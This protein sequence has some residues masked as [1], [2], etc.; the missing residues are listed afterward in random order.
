M[1]GD[2]PTT[3]QRAPL[4]GEAAGA[5]FDLGFEGFAGTA[6]SDDQPGDLIARYRLIALLGEGGFGLVWSAEQ[7]EPIQRELALKLI[8]RGMDSREI[9][10]RFEAES[11]AL[12]MMDHP[13]IAAVL[14][15]GTSADGRPWFAM[16]LVKGTPLVSYCD[17]RKL[18]VRERIELF[19]PV[20]QA[21]Q[22]AHQKAILHR[23]LKPTNILVAEID[24]KPV[25]KVIDFGIAKALGTPQE[26]AASLLQTRIG[27][28]VGT[29]QYMSPE[30]AGSVPDVDTRSDIYSL[31][32]ILYELLTGTTSLSPG[33]E[34]REPSDE[35]LRRIRAEEAIR[36]SLRLQADSVAS[37]EVAACRGTEPAR[38]RKSLRGDLD[39]IVLKALEKDRRRRYGT[40]TAF[41]TDLRRYLDQ[42]PVSAAA[43]TWSY[44]FPKFARR[45]RVAFVTVGLVAAALIAGTVVSLNQAAR[46]KQAGALAEQNR[47]LAEKNRAEAEESSAR[48]MKAMEYFLNG[49]TDDPRLKQADFQDLRRSLLEAAL[50]MYRDLAKS[51]GD[52]P[53]VQDKRSWALGRLGALYLELGQPGKAITAMREAMELSEALAAGDP[54]N[55]LH[56]RALSMRLNN[57]SLPLRQLDE[58][59]EAL[60]LQRRGVGISD[61][62]AADF[63]G[64]AKYR[65]DLSTV[66]VNFGA[67][68]REE[69]LLD[70]SIA[71]H[72]RA[73]E[74]AEK[75]VADFPGDP[76]YLGQ[77]AFCHGTLA[78]SLQGR[79]DNGGAEQSYRRAREIWEKLATEQVENTGVRGNLAMNSHNLG[80]LLTMIGRPAEGLE[81]LRHGQD[82]YQRL[83]AEF[84]S[85]PGYRDSLATCRYS[86]GKALEKLGRTWEAESEFQQAL[87][88]YHAL[89][90]DF[91]GEAEHPVREGLA[92]E[93]L[94]LLQ[95]HERKWDAARELY[96]RSISRHR[97]ALELRPGTPA[98]RNLI[99]DR[100]KA[101]AEMGLEAGDPHAVVKAALQI[102]IAIPD[103]WE[104]QEAAA[105]LVARALP[106]I[107]AHASMSEEARVEFIARCNASIV[108][109]LRRAIE[110]GY[111]K[112]PALKTDPDFAVLLSNPD[113]L[114]LKEAPPDSEE[115]APSRLTF[116]YR[117]DDPGKRIWKRDGD[118]W[119][120]TS[121]SGRTN[122]FRVGTRVRVNGVSGT[123]VT[124]TTDADS[125]F[126]IPDKIAPEPRILFMR[127][128]TGEW[129]PFVAIREME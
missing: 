104:E 111:P 105:R 34:K 8:K 39:W 7:T 72:H 15:A 37:R 81:I 109:L 56:R 92:L 94:A 32:V 70:E 28:V 89:A 86:C 114:A 117:H 5:L 102:P 98:H 65:H 74:V 35:V 53:S 87:S 116:E 78:A 46:A 13:N 43:P 129:K 59:A 38:L 82:L 33:T 73:L 12:A 14:D 77:L 10:A 123:E 41:A 26:A 23:D 55:A 106:L 93:A 95:R 124:R 119:T 66:L 54:G 121:P 67:A 101:L 100:Y 110:L 48:A 49:V 29:L 84:P 51:S 71:A 11:Q 85:M 52:T 90:I 25:P 113:F 60:A 69:G 4:S 79:Q 16:E 64:E 36:P 126:F 42:E 122:E 31:G 76:V 103:K 1:P 115:N 45:N 75:L 3:S 96:E 112:V 27:T 18:S 62:L 17:S 120:E 83:A 40:A 128:G 127:N 97:A 80:S 108:S 50:P 107:Q 9:I 19:I 21:V 91:P 20:C 68:L 118:T 6:P 63:P 44:R 30:Q 47:Q 99:R 2:P 58:R 24:G 61:K 125:H 22:H 88:I 57:L